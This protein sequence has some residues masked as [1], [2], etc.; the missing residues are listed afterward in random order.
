MELTRVG[1]RMCRQKKK[2][3]SQITM[4]EDFI[5]PDIKPDME[6]IAAQGGGA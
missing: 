5:V 2:V 4:D 1:I 6:L 3:V